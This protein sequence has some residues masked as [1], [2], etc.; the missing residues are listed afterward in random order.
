MAGLTDNEL[1]AL[2]YFAIGVSSEGGDV[3]YRLSFAGNIRNDAHGNPVMHPAGNSGYSIGTLQTDLGQR[4]AVATELT[5]AYQ[6]WARTAHPDWVLSDAQRTHTIADLRRTGHQINDQHGRPLDATVKSHLDAFMASE[7]GMNFVH[8]HDMAQVDKLMT[9]VIGPLQKT[10]LY[11]HASEQ[12]QAQLATITAKLYNQ[13]EKYGKDVLGQ[14]ERG[15]LHSVKEVSSAL[16]GYPDYVTAGRDHALAGTALFN[17]L[18]AAGANNPMH[19]AW[20]DVAAN[21]GVNP[22]RLGADSTHPHL[23]HEYAVI[24][25]AF[26]DPHH[27]RSMVQALEQGGSYANTQNNRGY[28]S[29][30]RDMVVWDRAG[31]GHALVNGQW[32]DVNSKDISLHNNA[33]KTLDVNVHRDG[34]DQRL[35]HVTHPGNHVRVQPAHAS[36]GVASGDHIQRAGTLREHDHA[37]PV[38][39][40]QQQLANL[41]YKGG[42]GKLIHPDG[43]FGKNTRVALEAFQKDH[44]LTSD[45]IA[46]AKTMDALRNA[47]RVAAPGL[48]D[49]THPGHAMY[50]QALKEV[51]NLDAK[52]GRASDH[53]SSNLAGVVAIAAH[54]K[55]LTRVDSVVLS[56]DG[57]RAYAVQG[58]LNS[59][60]KQIAEV[61]VSKAVGQPLEQS[62]QQ[63]QP[64]AQQ[65]DASQ[66]QQQQQQG[67][68]Q[69]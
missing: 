40:L 20:Q 60:H 27:S 36:P 19:A 35:L 15:E 37:P 43:D 16:N 17:D 12:E 31:H 6:N 34:A 29:E 24:K 10:D 32:S 2:S 14:I 11:K 25:G 49:K 68:M 33:D 42:D 22:T 59:P 61:D 48:A 53:A 21:P 62:S 13:S 4:P 30:G 50:E 65:Q 46:G 67:Q 64:A 54:E 56:D 9:N 69:R 47:N 44:G 55:G 58:D 63:W 39:D 38:K 7:A 1:R 51:A 52:L 18:R 5:D 45:G 66:Q 23:P 41:G 57:K 8:Q 28:L 3:A 26:V